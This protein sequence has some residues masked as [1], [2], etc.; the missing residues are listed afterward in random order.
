[1]D[2]LVWFF[3]ESTLALSACLVVLLF[4]LLVHWRRGGRG[5]PLLIGLGVAVLLLIVQALVVTRRERADHILRR[6]ETDIVASRPDA[7]AAALSARFYVTE[8][9]M[10][11]ADF[12]EL[13][14]RAMRR[15]DVHTL[16]QSG[17]KIQAGASDTFE[18]SVTYWADVST[19]EYRGMTHSRWK[20]VFV[21][22]ESGWRILSV[23]PTALDGRPVAGWR[24]VPNP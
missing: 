18:I 22:E 24:G 21:R 2:S 14:R 17:L 13:V 12:L 3:F 1:M 20:I 16:R 15:V 8:P 19:P 7:I 10:D 23:E 11:R 9:E 4:V 6:I 5:R